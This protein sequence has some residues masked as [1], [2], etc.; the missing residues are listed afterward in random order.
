ML[1][2]DGAQGWADPDEITAVERGEWQSLRV[3]ATLD[4][5]ICHPRT[6]SGRMRWRRADRR[7]RELRDRARYVPLCAARDSDSHTARRR[8]TGRRCSNSQIV[9][10]EEEEEYGFDGDDG[11][12]GY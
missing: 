11:V 8:S 5:A 1:L 3:A 10:G 7:A 4:T 12:G 2:A 9:V 6:L